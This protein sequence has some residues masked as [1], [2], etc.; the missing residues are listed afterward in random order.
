MIHSRHGNRKGLPK[1]YQNILNTW[2]HE[3]LIYETP[4]KCNDDWYVYNV[5]NVKIYISDL[6]YCDLYYCDLYCC[7]VILYYYILGVH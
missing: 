3:E 4:P 1:E 6:Y 2:K 5:N 7:V